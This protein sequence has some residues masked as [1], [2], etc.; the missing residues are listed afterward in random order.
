MCLGPF[1]FCVLDWTSWISLFLIRRVV[2]SLSSSTFFFI[3]RF[4]RVVRFRR[5]Y[6]SSVI[7]S[8][9]SLS[10][11][12]SIVRHAVMSFA[13]VVNVSGTFVLVSS[14][15]CRS[16]CSYC[17]NSFRESWYVEW[18]AFFAPSCL[19]LFVACCFWM[20]S[21]S[22]MWLKLKMCWLLRDIW[23]F[24]HMGIYTSFPACGGSYENTFLWWCDAVPDIFLG[25]FRSHM[26]HLFASLS[27]STVAVFLCHFAPFLCEKMVFDEL[28]GDLVLVFS[29]WFYFLWF[30]FSGAS[31]F[32]SSLSLLM[33]LFACASCCCLLLWEMVCQWKKRIVKL[34]LLMK[35]PAM[36]SFFSF[37]PVSWCRVCCPMV[38]V[39]CCPLISKW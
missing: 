24:G 27:P 5:S 30:K 7:P 36:C 33:L 34:L 37:V 21:F 32:L 20:P 6:P 12:L 35:T 28:F 8:C 19:V 13:F 25:R 11:S 2:R 3:H 22:W 10:S 1:C 9:R 17:F 29:W 18:D 23:A 14:I 39:P 15:V 26:L 4:R 31:P 38:G 16:R